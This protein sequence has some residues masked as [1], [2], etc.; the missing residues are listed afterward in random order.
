MVLKEHY[1]DRTF[2]SVD[3][4]HKGWP[5]YLQPGC[6]AAPTAT[7]LA[8][9]RSRSPREFASSCVSVA[10]SYHQRAIARRKRASQSVSND[11]DGAGD[12]DK[13]ICAH[14]P[15]GDGSVALG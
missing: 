8:A 6:P 14:T 13:L 5:D 3:L 12:G 7:H 11:S 15:N 2:L 9:S 10:A 4:A 1:G